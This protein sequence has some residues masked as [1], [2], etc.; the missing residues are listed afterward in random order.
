MK[1]LNSFKSGQQVTSVSTSKRFKSMFVDVI[2]PFDP[3]TISG[4]MVWYKADEGVTKDGSDLVS[5]WNDQSGQGNN[6]TQATATNKP[7]FVN[8]NRNSLPTINFDGIDNFMKLTNFSG[9]GL[10][11]PYYIFIACQEPT[12]SPVSQGFFTD[13]NQNDPRLRTLSGVY[14][15]SDETDLSG[16][17]TDP[18]VWHYYTCFFNGVSS[19]LRRDGT[20][21]LSGNSG[22]GGTSFNGLTIGALSAPS[23]FANMQYG[24]FLIYNVNIGAT[25]RDL[26]EGYL[27]N[28]WDI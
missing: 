24:E 14:D 23:N 13:D 2:P 28:K 20:S 9:G 4:L 19:D 27:A 21:I 26:V 15:M 7:L 10:V 17:T 18:S 25:D 1:F 8:N 3:S 6:V 22:S 12:S 16:G 5:Q 11:H